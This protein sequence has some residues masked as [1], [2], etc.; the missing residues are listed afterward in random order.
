MHSLDVLSQIVD[1]IECLLTGLAL[2]R[3]IFVVDAVHVKP[4]IMRRWEHFITLGTG[5]FPHPFPGAFSVSGLIVEFVHHYA[6]DVRGQVLLLRG[7]GGRRGRTSGFPLHFRFR[8]R[9][10]R[11]EGELVQDGRVVN[12]GGRR[13]VDHARG[14]GLGGLIS[15][16]VLRQQ[17]QKIVA[18]IDEVLDKNC[19]RLK[20]QQDD[21]S[22]W[23]NDLSFGK[24]QYFLYLQL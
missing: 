11:R 18:S 24:N 2:D 21:C 4:Q 8:F 23:P 6:Q 1:V 9:F 3:L 20:Y 10:R 16:I 19:L 15:V 7:R 22:T 13:R 5:M 17:W 12:G 14:C